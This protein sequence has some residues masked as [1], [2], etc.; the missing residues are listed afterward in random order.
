MRED[1]VL[2]RLADGQDA[3]Q[4]ARATGITVHTSRGYIKGILGS[5]TRT[6][7][8]KPSSWP[9]A[10]ASSPRDARRRTPAIA[11]IDDGDMG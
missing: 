5:S 7:S 3:T 1:Q 4:I 10:G 2:Q 8:S 9:S 6:T 11:S